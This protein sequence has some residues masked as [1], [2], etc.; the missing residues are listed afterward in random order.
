[1]AS[2]VDEDEDDIEESE[3][4]RHVGRT[5]SSFGS[6]SHSRGSHKLMSIVA[7]LKKVKPVYWVVG[8]GGA[9]LAVDYLVEGERSIVSSLYHG[10][11]GHGGGSGGGD[12]GGGR[13]GGGRGP[14]PGGGGGAVLPSVSMPLY[15]AY[16]A[17]Y[18]A[19]YPFG[20]HF[21][22]DFGHPFAHGLVHGAVS[23]GGM[24]HGGRG[25]AR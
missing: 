8:L 18:Y 11:F 19:L 2:L 25:G 7:K 12:G 22:H 9:A 6:R 5:S 16:P 21:G 17:A 10:I 1:M 24:T 15:P 20:G 13:G 4:A 14:Q 3:P 23:H